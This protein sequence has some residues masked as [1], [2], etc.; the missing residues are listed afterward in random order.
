V[1]DV[2][3]GK[4]S[5]LASGPTLPDPTTVADAKRITAEHR[6]YDRFPLALRRW[7][8]EGKIPETPKALPRISKLTFF[9]TAG[10]G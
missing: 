4:E 8:A 1:S 9:A 7:L 5:A 10:V 3:A 2:P 6:L